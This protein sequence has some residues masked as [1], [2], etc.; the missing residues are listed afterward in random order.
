[1]TVLSI[2]DYRF[3]SRRGGNDGEIYRWSDCRSRKKDKEGEEG[4]EGEEASERDE[5]RVIRNVTYDISV[6]LLRLIGQKIYYDW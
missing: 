3:A 4:E 2:E 1:M 5:K 6:V